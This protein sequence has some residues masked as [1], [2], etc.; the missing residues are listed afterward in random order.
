MR[1]ELEKYEKK[2][3]DTLYMRHKL[4]SVKYNIGT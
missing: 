1:H 3:N 4:I 2:K